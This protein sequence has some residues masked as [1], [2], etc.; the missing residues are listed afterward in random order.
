MKKK[1][2]KILSVLISLCMLN[3][4]SV[5]A[6]D[7]SDGIATDSPETEIPSELT[8]TAPDIEDFNSDEEIFSDEEEN[9]EFSSE[10]P[11]TDMGEAQ[12]AGA[13][14]TSISTY[15]Y[16][17]VINAE[18]ESDPSVATTCTTYKG[19]NLESQDYSTYGSTVKSYLTTSPDGQLMRIQSGA[20]D[21][22]LLVEYYDTSY[23]LKKTVTLNLSLPVFGAFYESNDNYYVLTGADNPNQNNSQEVYRVTKYSKN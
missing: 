8:D 10:I 5:S 6:A 12:V 15:A 23:N 4:T 19:Q 21:G 7:F 11:D 9:E 3:C 1:K 14:D 20:L 17:P 18:I 2:V 16:N 13:L 22:K